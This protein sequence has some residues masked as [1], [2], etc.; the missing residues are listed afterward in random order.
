MLGEYVTMYSNSK[1]LGD[2]HIGDHVVIAANAY[3][4]DTDIPDY[5]IVY[6]QYPK[7]IV[8]TGQQEKIDAIRQRI[9]LE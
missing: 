2:S 8:K 1:I 5:S 3:I 7:L 9:W 6:G 4:K